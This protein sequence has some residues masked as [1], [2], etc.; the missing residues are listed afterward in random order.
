[1]AYFVKIQ[2]NT[3]VDI[4]KT[5]DEY[6]NSHRDLYKGQWIR[7]EGS[8]PGLGYNWDGEKFTN[9]NASESDRDE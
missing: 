7:V 9:V 3:V 1:M 8:Y 6:F 4:R 5:S 2:D